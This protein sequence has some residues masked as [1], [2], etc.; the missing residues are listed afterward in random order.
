MRDFCVCGG[1]NMYHWRLLMF[2]TAITTKQQHGFVYIRVR[3]VTS[4]PLR[5]GERERDRLY[6]TLGG[7]ENR[8]MLLCR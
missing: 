8:R 5:E 2:Y 1:M 4:T 3:R 6:R 7:S